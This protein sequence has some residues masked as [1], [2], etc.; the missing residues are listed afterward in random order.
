MSFKHDPM[1]ATGNYDRL[2]IKSDDA[3][4]NKSPPACWD[5]QIS[6]GQSL[7]SNKRPALTTK[8]LGGCFL[9]IGPRWTKTLWYRE[10]YD[11]LRSLVVVIYLHPW[12]TRP[13]HMMEVVWEGKWTIRRWKRFIGYIL[14]HVRIDKPD[15][16]IYHWD[17]HFFRETLLGLM[18]YLCMI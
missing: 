12:Q 8:L 17:P 14:S 10:V 7:R 3:E 11:N 1:L 16:Q 2:W 13:S 18:Q 15:I 9:R 6:I 5:K 4:K